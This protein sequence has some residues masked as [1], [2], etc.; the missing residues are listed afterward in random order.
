[1]DVI[2]LFR[3]ELGAGV[4]NRASCRVAEKLGMR[5]EGLMRS[6]A[7]T[8]AQQP[9]DLYLYAML[10]DDPREDT[11]ERY[12][13][14]S[15]DDAE[16]ITE[17]DFSRGLITAVVQDENDGQVLMVAHMNE[18]AYQKTL[19]TGRAW[20]WSRSRERLWEKGETSGNFLDVRAVTLDCDGDA[21][22]LRVS[23]HGPS[24]HTGAWT[25]FHNPVGQGGAGNP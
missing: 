4:E 14:A 16:A 19:Q 12:A 7:L 22:L 6:A 24:C 5:R 18:E 13:A 21:V 15:A 11:G 1:L 20:F 23:P 17:P 9:Y 3:L 8:G 2:G 25:C 10:R